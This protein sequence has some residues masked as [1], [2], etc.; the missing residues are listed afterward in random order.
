MADA[1]TAAAQIRA[2]INP[3]SDTEAIKA[4]RMAMVHRDIDTQLVDPN[5]MGLVSA[6]H[7][8]ARPDYS[9]ENA[10]ASVGRT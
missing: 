3:L 5:T 6:T 8:V 1:F 10:R 7:I 9:E 4:I 2:A